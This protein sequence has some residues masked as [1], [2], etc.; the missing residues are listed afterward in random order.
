MPEQPASTTTRDV[1]VIG[2]GPAGEVAA[3]RLVAGGLDV[4][5]VEPH[6]VGGE[7]SY[8]ACMPSKTLLRPA[9]AL[10]EAARLPG[11]A[12][13]VT[14][15]LDAAA[16]LA[17][18][19]EVVHDLDDAAQ[20]PF[21][22]DRGIALHRGHGRLVGPRRVAVRGA[23]GG[24]TELEAR[25]AVIVATGSTASVPPIDGLREARPWTN[26][27]AT[28]AQTVPPR[29]AILG[30]GVVAV[31][32][33]DAY[34]GLG[35]HVTMVVRGGGILAREEPF[36]SDELLASLRERGVDVRLETEIVRV[37]R[38]ESGGA[39]T[40][41]LA[42]S[43]GHDAGTLEADELLVAA[44]RTPNTAAVVDELDGV[45]LGPA[46]F[47]PTDRALAVA[48]GDDLYAVGDVNGR[49]LLTHQGKYQAVVAADAILGRFDAEI[50]GT[51][52]P[53]TRVV[54]TE[55][56]VAATG[57]TLATARTAGLEVRAIDV[58]SDATAGASFTGRGVG[59]T[60][61]FVLDE[62][63]GV[64]VGVTFTGAG[65]DEWLH[66]A[67]IAVTAAVPVTTLRHAVAAF[68]S[69]TEVWLRF[70]ERMSLAG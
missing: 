26:R 1:I 24:E 40:L 27:E 37:R 28:T 13:A 14:G 33:A 68:P 63:R 59:G 49:N 30:G 16:V 57:H 47:L 45:E 18:R 70:L 15:S 48:G 31:E 60:A 36:V 22:E 69:R 29:L 8:Y 54:F 34:A 66:A 56:Q 4:A 52:A 3:G 51:E 62:S 32:M 25:R 5:I 10:A 20:L 61:R 67:T 39:L 12:A 42:G 58:A 17:R 2:A 46:G 38:P 19:D 53:P 23:D 35:A 55:P 43:Q 50:R 7:C 21:L 11:A 41:S 64:L 9:H 44:G 65:V 6:L